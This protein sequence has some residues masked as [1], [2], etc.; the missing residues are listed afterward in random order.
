ME[1]KIEKPTAKVIGQDSNVFVTLGICSKALKK[2][3]QHEQARE[4]QSKVM[5]SGSYNE[6]LAIMMEYCELE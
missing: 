4:M 5:D 3:G 1:T 6:A 2:A